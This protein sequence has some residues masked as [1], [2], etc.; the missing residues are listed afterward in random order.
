VI[1]APLDRAKQAFLAVLA[2]LVIAI[3]VWAMLSS[4]GC[5]PP[6]PAQTAKLAADVCFL[7]GFERMVQ[8]AHPEL[9]PAD[10]SI[11]AKLG[12]TTDQLCQKLYDAGAPPPA[13]S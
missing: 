13:P 10:D 7:R 5:T 3:P 9:K 8:E 1:S 4:N 12:A 2:V 11:G 6:T